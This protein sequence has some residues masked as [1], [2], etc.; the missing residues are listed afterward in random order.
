MQTHDAKALGSWGPRVRDAL[1]IIAEQ[2]TG[3]I[4]DLVPIR[5]GRMLES[6]FAFFR[7]AAAVMAA[8]LA[9]SPS[10]GVNVLSCGDAHLANFGFFGTPERRIAFDVNDFDE[11]GPAPW[12]WDVKRLVTSV[13]LAAAQNGASDDQSW[14]AARRT[15]KAYRKALGR[16]ARMSSLQRF[17]AS[18]DT[19][20]LQQV[21][22]G[23]AKG[24]GKR[25]ERVAQSSVRQ[26]AVVEGHA[27]RHT[28][29][30][31]LHKFAL[32][33]ASGSVRLV[34]QPPLTRHTDLMD[35]AAGK[36]LFQS[37]LASAEADVHHLL[38]GFDVVDV[39]LRVVGVGSVGT[40]CFIVLLQDADGTDLL[41]QVKEAQASVL[42]RYGGMAASDAPDAEESPEPAASNPN[43]GHRV[44]RA[45]RILQSHSDS[46]LGWMRGPADAASGG[47]DVDF[48]W[49]Q[50]RDMKSSVDLSALDLDTLQATAAA[51]ATLLARAHAQSRAAVLLAPSLRGRKDLDAALADSA[52][53]YAART[54]RDHAA[55]AFAVS[56]GRLEAQTGL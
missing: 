10:S 27:R 45:Q 22:L 40:R 38:A 12:E 35:A 21:I 37:Y 29:Q 4:P 34:D 28:S 50:F 32:K 53:E 19:Q 30:Q 41:L 36:R 31:A 23:Q 11:G 49:R 1:E 6:P 3:R 55:L 33:E 2:N 39:V 5:R 16:F 54:V 25:R 44:V 9:A 56:S 14:L 17:Y 24:H 20:S 42:Q 15:A 43:H 47:N 7:G 52:R 51:C 18:V 46:F 26:L 48:Y 8:D 13:V